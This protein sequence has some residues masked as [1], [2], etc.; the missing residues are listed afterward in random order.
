M[1]KSRDLTQKFLFKVFQKPATKSIFVGDMWAF[2]NF[3]DPNSRYQKFLENGKPRFSKFIDSLM[4]YDKAIIPTQ[5][6]I[7]LT[8]LIGVLGERGIIDLLEADDIGF[9]R[10]R[11]AFGYI[12]N[13]GGIQSYV[14]SKNKEDGKLESF[15]DDAQ[16]IPWA[17]KGLN[18]SPKE[19]PLIT[20]I[21]LNKVVTIESAKI[22]EIIRHETYIDILKSSDL[23]NYFGIRNTNMDRLTGIGPDQVRICGGPD[24][25]YE[26]KDE[27]DAAMEI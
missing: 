5:D 11:G 4:L 21:I 16:V 14:I 25:P 2:F 22:T 19:I 23:R 7:S 24:S 6:Y 15:A 18:P 1:E 20:K 3:D 17:L 9:V 10:L 13:G 26:K 8:V 12:G 27:I